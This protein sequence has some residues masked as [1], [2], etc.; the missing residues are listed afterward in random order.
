MQ[1]TYPIYWTPSVSFS[2]RPSRADTGPQ[3]KF[4]DMP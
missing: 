2:P 1:W 3:K 4:V